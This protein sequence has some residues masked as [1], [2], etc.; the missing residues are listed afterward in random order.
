M[1]YTRK[2]QQPVSVTF[3]V[4]WIEEPITIPSVN[5]L[6]MDILMKAQANQDP[7]LLAGALPDELSTL[8]DAASGIEMQEFLD[9][10]AEVSVKAEKE[11]M[12]ETE[13]EAARTDSLFSRITRGLQ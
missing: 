11:A 1:K 3:S 12:R 9:K 4:S 10:W 13:R 2:P 6:P 5:S 7:S 8:L